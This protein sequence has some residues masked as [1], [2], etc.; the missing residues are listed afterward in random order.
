MLLLCG[1]LAD[2]IIQGSNAS[3]ARGGLENQLQQLNKLAGEKAQSVAESTQAQGRINR[4]LR[5]AEPTAFQAFVLDYLSANL[6]S[7]VQ[8]E[9]VD[10]EVTQEEAEDG[11]IDNTYR[12]II[13]GR[14]NNEKRKG[15]D[16]VLDLQSE[17]KKQERVRDVFFG[18]QPRAD[19]A[20][21]YS[22][23]MII[24]PQYVSI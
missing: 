22:F 23:E 16:W 6:R 21:W 12:L 13:R 18:K 2:G 24:E 10:L 7:E 11:S 15:H 3:E 19:T 1:K 14:A 20:A 9:L 17:L 5:E 4:L 8:L